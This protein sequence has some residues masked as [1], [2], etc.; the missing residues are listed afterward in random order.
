MAGA[1]DTKVEGG[2]AAATQQG[3]LNANPK[4]GLGGAE[5]SNN[6]AAAPAAN[7][8][9]ATEPPKEPKRAKVSG[10]GDIPEDADLIELSPKALKDRLRR[11]SRADLKQ[12]FGT[13]DPDQI[14]K[15]L[16][17]LATLRKEKKESEL[18]KLGELE[19]E[20][21]LREEAEGRA[22]QAEQRAK[23][24]QE[25]RIFDREE[26][27]LARLF[28]KHLDE[29]YVDQ[30][31]TGFARHLTK[32]F[33]K[34][35]LERMSD[36]QRDAEAVK[37]CEERVKAKPKLSKSYESAKEEEIRKAL[38]AESRGKAPVTNGSSGD[39]RR[40]EAGAGTQ[41]KNFA[42]GKGASY[43]DIKAAGFS[44]K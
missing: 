17:E 4:S 37:F 39:K 24:V 44:Y 8:A 30:E 32:N 40:P 31:L 41:P 23:R 22:T 18:A 38:K 2:A 12:R 34:K 15:D 27:H 42:P 7:T 14:K 13:D 19:R 16:D 28:G 20:K 1:D 6:A 11:A 26:N 35:Q 33:S 25:D 10:D 43:A 36:K 9:A 5:F 3:P 29:D 21:K